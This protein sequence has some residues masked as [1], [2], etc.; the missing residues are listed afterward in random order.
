MTLQISLDS[1]GPGLHDR[2]RGAGSHAK[3]LVGIGLARDLGFRVRVA[4]TYLPEDAPAAGDLD[5]TLEN[6]GIEPDDRLIRP[7]AKEGFADSGVAITVDSIE[8]EPTL[9]AD[10]AWWHPVG[11]TNP[12]LKV[13]TSRCLSRLFWRSCVMWSPCRKGLVPKDDPCSAAP[14]WV[15]SA[16]SP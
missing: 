13:P 14:N 12:A 4:A 3:A 15:S 5:T 11:V 8:P 6:L 7:V 1:A 10:G 9:T 2:Q 16:V